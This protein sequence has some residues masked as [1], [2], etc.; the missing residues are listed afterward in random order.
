MR[1]DPIPGIQANFC[2]F[3]LV[4]NLDPTPEYSALARAGLIE[5]TIT[6]VDFIPWVMGIKKWEGFKS[7]Q[8]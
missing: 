2:S 7:L 3:L 4:L 8:S 5:R 1:D 6:T